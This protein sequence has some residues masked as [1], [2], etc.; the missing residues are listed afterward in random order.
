MPRCLFAPPKLVVVCTD[1]PGNTALVQLKSICLRSSS[2]HNRRSITS[3]LRPLMASQSLR[4]THNISTPPRRSSN[5]GRGT[6]RRIG[7]ASRGIDTPGNK[8]TTPTRPASA[9]LQLKRTR[10]NRPVGLSPR[11]VRIRTPPRPLSSGKT[12]SV[13][14]QER[15]MK[16]PQTADFTGKPFGDA[17]SKSGTQKGLT[18]SLLSRGVRERVTHGHPSHP[19][20]REFRVFRSKFNGEKPFL[21]QA[22]GCTGATDQGRPRIRT[23]PDTVSTFQERLAEA[24]EEAIPLLEQLTFSNAD[25]RRTALEFVVP[26]LSRTELTNMEYWVARNQNRI[27][28][29]KASLIDERKDR[30]RPDGR[31]YRPSTGNGAHRHEHCTLQRRPRTAGFVPVWK[32]DPHKN[33]YTVDHQWD[34]VDPNQEPPSSARRVNPL[35]FRSPMRHSSLTAQDI[36]KVLEEKDSYMPQNNAGHHPNKV[37]QELNSGK[38][39]IPGEQAPAFMDNRKRYQTVNMVGMPVE[40]KPVYKYIHP[41][42]LGHNNNFTRMRNFRK[43]RTG[44]YE[45]QQIRQKEH[46][47]KAPVPKF[48][49]V[50]Q[51]R[52]GKQMDLF[53]GKISNGMKKVHR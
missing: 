38:A 40:S 52:Q 53:G 36:F 1:A 23:V 51:H 21:Y 44:V 3:Q 12:R 32:K 26:G 2:W 5:L 18:A 13:T 29:I 28:L 43:Y 9:S 31:T 10:D 19:S 7:G 22:A 20:N 4:R 42:E 33:K 41:S 49:Q 11:N 45:M 48:M 30:L 6:P 25:A 34:D 35:T 17:L 46:K 27:R 8:I 14:W 39:L 50:K 47:I 16:R 15:Q 24:G 37:K